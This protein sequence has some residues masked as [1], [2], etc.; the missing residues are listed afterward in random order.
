ME[1]QMSITD[2]FRHDTSKIVC[3]SEIEQAPIEVTKIGTHEDVN[4]DGEIYNEDCLEVFKR[5]PDKSIDLVVTDCPY[6]ICSGGCTT[7]PNKIASYL[8]GECGGMLSHR[9]D[10]HDSI[11]EEYDPTT[12]VKKGKLFKHNE[13][14]FSEW[15]PEVY[16]VLKDDTHCYIMINPRNLKDLWQAANDAGFAFQQLIVWDKGNTT[17][18]KYYLNAYELI[19][20]LRKGKAKNINN[21]GTKNILR[22]A[23]IIGCKEHP[24]EKPVELM[25]VLIENSSNVGDK[26]L[27]PFMGVG[28]VPLACKKTGRNY[29]GIE[30]DEKYFLIAKERL[31]R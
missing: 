8:S 21:M 9:K 27:D 13:I 29:I 30:L 25:Q 23:N 6:R 5:I 10:K 17:P 20:M 3:V 11:F 1:G 2:I 31:R 24:T 16:R 4:A 22:I 15:V 26:V 28:G 12:Y 19:L 7:D 18:N 14:E